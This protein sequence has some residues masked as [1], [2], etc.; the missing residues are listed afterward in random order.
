MLPAASPNMCLNPRFLRFEATLCPV[1]AR[2]P[3][4]GG[5]GFH[6]WGGGCLVYGGQVQ[7][8]ADWSFS[9]KSRYRLN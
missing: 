5:V 4:I 2:G 3:I 8:G 9:S 1:Q 7:T 6:Y